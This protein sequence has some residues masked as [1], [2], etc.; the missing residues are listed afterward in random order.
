MIQLAEDVF[1]A[2]HDPEQLD[3][4]E[5][6]IKRFQLIH[7][8]SVGE[9][10]EGDGPIAWVLVLPTTKVLMNQF[11]EN[12]INEKELFYLTPIHTLYES[13]YLCSAMVLDEYR[14]QGIAK[15]LTMD[16]ITMIRK[17]HP[18]EYLFYWPFTEEGDLAAK[19]LA[20]ECKLP[21]LLRMAQP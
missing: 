9:Y 14:R 17:D 15:R 5:E 21:L 4:N 1:D 16:A 10:D 7:P 2:R 6:V 11:L 13:I 20:K 19:S 3:V 18:I 12:R 8:A